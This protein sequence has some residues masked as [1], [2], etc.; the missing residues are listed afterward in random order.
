VREENKDKKMFM[1]IPLGE[2][3]LYAMKKEIGVAA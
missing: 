1:I 2:G 3:Y